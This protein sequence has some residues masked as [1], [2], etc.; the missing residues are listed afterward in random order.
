MQIKQEFTDIKK[1]VLVLF[2]L[3]MAFICAA[4]SPVLPFNID[5]KIPRQI[6]VGSETLLAL[7]AA[8]YEIIMGENTPTVK[9]AT[10]EIADGLAL[11]F[12]TKAVNPVNP[13]FK[14]SGKAIQIC[15]EDKKLAAQVSK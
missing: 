5:P 15:V 4:A 11:V 13:L 12:G 10:G 8:N 2:L 1:H 6:T 7:K 3:C 14:S 9:L